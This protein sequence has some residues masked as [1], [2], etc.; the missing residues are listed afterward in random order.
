MSG[1]LHMDH[2]RTEKSNEYTLAVDYIELNSI[3]TYDY[4]WPCCPCKMVG[5]QL[6]QGT[7][8]F[9]ISSYRY[10]QPLTPVLCSSGCDT[11]ACDVV[12]GELLKRSLIAWARSAL[13]EASPTIV[14]ACSAFRRATLRLQSAQSAISRD[15]ELMIFDV[16]KKVFFND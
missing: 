14:A 11:D 5:W 10:H 12:V 7:D 13:S 9:A 3:P 8:R 16:R 2:A 15:E 4:R 6:R 1:E